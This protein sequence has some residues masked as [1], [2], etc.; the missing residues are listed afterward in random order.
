MC[1]LVAWFWLCSLSI[2]VIGMK[3]YTNLNLNR[4]MKT[5]FF[6]DFKTLIKMIFSCIYC[7]N[8][9]R[10]IKGATKFDTHLRKKSD[11]ISVY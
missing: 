5:T 11:P 2:L 3:I 8:N 7:S 1:S 4:G 10:E 6:Y 9:G